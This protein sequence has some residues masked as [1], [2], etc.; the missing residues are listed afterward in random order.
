AAIAPAAPGPPLAC[1]PS[2]RQPI[3][4]ASV[5][6]IA[7]AAAPWAV[8]RRNSRR[9]GE[10]GLRNPIWRARR[11]TARNSRDMASFPS[12]VNFSVP[13][14]NPTAAAAGAKQEFDGETAGCRL[15]VASYGL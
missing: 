6:A 3:R 11:S 15:G 10:T 13:G 8:R 1:A 9:L 4:D 5:G 12:L 14:R 7:S 2:L